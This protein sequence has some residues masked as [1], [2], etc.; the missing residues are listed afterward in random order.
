MKPVLP[1]T[2]KQVGLIAQNI[3]AMN[4]ECARAAGVHKRQSKNTCKSE[5]YEVYNV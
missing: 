1:K 2:K 5:K 4:I 3:E